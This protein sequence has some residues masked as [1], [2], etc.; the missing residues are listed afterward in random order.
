MHARRSWRD[1]GLRTK[2]AAGVLV[3][4][5]S[6]MAALTAL[7]VTGMSSM[8][9]AAGKV[10]SQGARVLAQV[11][12]ARTDVV[13][14][15]MVVHELM[16]A[17]SIHDDTAGMADEI[18]AHL[19]GARST[20][21][22][23]DSPALAETQQH[24]LDEWAAYDAAIRGDVLPLLEQGDVAG[25]GKAMFDGSD[26]H[27]D[28]ANVAMEDLTTRSIEVASDA[29]RSAHDQ[30]LSTRKRLVMVAFV[31][32]GLSVAAAMFIAREISRP[33][34]A[35]VDALSRAAE[36]DLT[37]RVAITSRD[38]LGRLG[39]A[40][41]RTVQATSDSVR[42]VRDS[43]KHL[44]DVSH[45]LS[46]LSVQLTA[47]ADQTRSRAESAGAAANQVSSN[48]ELAAHGA[49]EA[50]VAVSEIAAS[51]AVAATSAADAVVRVR[52]TTGVVLSL[53]D[54]SAAIT[55]IVKVINGVADQTHLLALNASIEAARAGQAGAGFAVVAGE[56]K[57]LARQTAA[58][59]DD[60]ATRIA[61][62][63]AD[64]GTAAS[65]FV[66]ITEVVDQ[67]DRMQSTMSS[68][69][70]EHT[71]TS[72][73]MTSAMSEAATGS[74]EISRTVALVATEAAETALAAGTVRDAAG[75]L[76]AVATELMEGIDYF[77]VTE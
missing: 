55:E 33:I 46:G 44:V 54:S 65:A 53:Q 75:E 72:A 15:E 63:Q 43:S 9:D 51:G 4:S 19:D 47:S 12:S 27:F 77:R 48:A 66:S 59:T 71:A 8:D 18:E 67:V 22:Q 23:I 26:A 3:T 76:G 16:V 31:V 32:A 29:R 14:T 21:E 45:R 68:A 64:A 24:F 49:E 13:S 58:A 57:E 70:E 61:G 6:G 5:L 74:T 50:R 69:V 11:G 42:R 35:S 25:A 38:E 30:F 17:I 40:L 36:G 34:R 41:N 28:A 1:L 7:S 39:E 52:E 2:V 37:Q 56:V 62:I 20:I 73:A 10:E 60:I